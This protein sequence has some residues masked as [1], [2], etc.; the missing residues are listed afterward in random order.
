MSRTGSLS[1]ALALACSAAT[2]S[3]GAYLNTT[4]IAA[5]SG[6]AASISRAEAISSFRL[7]NRNS[8][9]SHRVDGSIAR[10]YGQAFST[11]PTSAISSQ[12]F[13]DRHADM[14]GVPVDEL[15]ARGPFEDGRHT[16]PIGYLP[17][18]DSYK[19]T[20][21]YYTQVKEGVPVFRSKLV[22]LVRNEAD[23]PLVLASS[24]LHDVR[25]LQLSPQL[26]RQTVDQTRIEAV[27]KAEFNATEVVV[28][29]TERMIFAG[30]DATPHAP[31]LADVSEVMIDGFAE[32]LVVT[33]AATGKL[34]YKENRI[35]TVDINGNASAI[36]SEGPAADFCAPEVSQPLPY[37]RVQG[38]GVEVFTDINGDFTIPNPGV[39]PV[40]VSATLDGRWF[41]VSDFLTSVETQSENVAPPGPANLEFNSA[42]N[43]E[44]IR[45]Q[46]NAYIAANEVR[47]LAIA[48]N[49]SYPTLNN[50]SFPISVNRTDGFCPGNAWYSP[51]EQSI[52][53]CLSSG[54]NTPNTAWTSVV[55]HEYGHHLVNAGGSGQGQYGEGT[56]DVMSVILLDNP[57]LGIGFFGSCG[58]GLRSA[59]NALQYPCPT[60]G[61]ACAPLYSACVW[62]T[63]N[64]LVVTEPTEYQNILAFLAVNSILVHSGSLITP[65]M[66][67][68]WLTLDDDDANIGN[69]TPHYEEIAAGFGNHNMEAPPLSL[70]DIS[71]PVALPSVV[72]PDGSTSITVQ[73]DEL[74]GN[75]DASSPMLMVDTGSGFTAVAM[76][77][78]SATQFEAS[79]P[80]A[81]CGS[82][83]SYYVTSQTTSG[84]VQTSPADAP[85]STFTA[86]SATGEPVA[87]FEDNFQSNLGWS[88]ANPSATDGQWNRGVPVACNRGDP[89]SDF[90]GSGSCYLTD[91]STNGGDCNSDVDGG[92]TV[93]TSPTMDA[94]GGNSV[95]SY[96]RWYDNS[97]GGSPN[98]DIFVVDV[99]DDDGATWMELETVGPGGSESNGGWFQKQFALGD[100]PGFEQND[101]FRIRFTA[102]DTGDGS[103][104]E[105]AIDAI[106][107][108]NVPCTSVCDADITMDGS[109]N[110]FDIS[111]YINLFSGGDAAADLAAPFGTLN[112][113]DV[114]AYITLYNA[115]CP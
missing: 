4:K 2:V 84:A 76:N 42:N 20:G 83:V 50:E 28:W 72:S 21:H 95:I 63:R 10:V 107:L 101:M 46:V 39:T 54:A 66:T 5:A 34:L 73:I 77:Q 87:V 113:F 23:S 96:A 64:E 47:D 100:I 110:F 108:L 115:G 94:S 14:W 15:V 13:I 93:L 51:S 67:I 45:A 58:G 22:L 89:G 85:A 92:S 17:D 38:N 80:S 104:V 36:A 1:I 114:S 112:F 71:Y 61:H 78:L 70:L 106:E 62:D 86:F 43:D 40:N 59:E 68:D 53:F 41:T 44:M 12:R 52:N 111:E 105:A 29:N 35:H 48:A 19:F 9:L 56:G 103:V 79:F 37:L 25:S 16:Q 57:T 33:D 102:S 26:M 98:A 91:N 8:D 74:N 3:G 24:Q 30:M 27:A 97:F 75:L 18:T 31:T 65:Q 7:T 6:H 32:F 81:D 11:G 55:H 69:G 88:V 49:P 60:D 109:L 90:D 82:Q 99:S